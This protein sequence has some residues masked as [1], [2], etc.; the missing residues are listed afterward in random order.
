MTRHPLIPLLLSSLIVLASSTAVS[1]TH[2]VAAPETVT[3]AV[4]VYEW[5]GDPSKPTATR[6]I[7]VSIFIDGHFEDAAVYLSRPVPL[8]LE[9]GNIYSIDE[10]G[11]S[12]GT[13][14]LTS[15]ARLQA[16]GTGA[17]TY[18]ATWLGYGRFVPPSVVKE[19]P[20]R[21]SRNPATIIGSNDDSRPH[22]VNRSPDANPASTGKTDP[23]STKTTTDTADSK[24]TSSTGTDIDRPT[25]RRRTPAEQKADQKAA[26]QS[27]VSGPSTSLNDDPDRPTLHR[28]TAAASTEDKS[29]LMGLPADLHQLT[30]VS[31]PAN[32]PVHPFARPWDDENEHTAI[33]RQLETM[34]HEQLAA[35]EKANP[36]PASAIPVAATT[37][38]PQTGTQTTTTPP[39]STPDAAPPKLE[40]RTTPSATAVTAPTPTPSGPAPS[41][42]A[43]PAT[44]TTA[45]KR[46]AP[47][48]RL[49]PAQRRKAAA[50][51]A[52]A[53]PPP[54]EPLLD[55]QVHEY[56]LSYGGAP[57]FVYTAHTAGEGAARRAI[58]L[59]AQM[60]E[61]DDN[62]L[63]LAL[64]S[65]TDDTHRDRTPEL[66]LVDAVD[67]DASNRASLLFELR[68][69]N[70]RQFALYRVL[71]GR[72]EQLF[73]SG[74]TQ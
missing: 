55:E 2:R 31:D 40:R 3:R 29:R 37:S 24:P 51:A 14:D 70:T 26:S 61:T 25:L 19:T 18:D 42:T 16:N 22:L 43:L 66:R 33:L 35:Y 57:T 73:L 11:V 4:G 45:A 9:Y 21:A 47:A 23:A 48:P 34:A 72:S 38:A 10:A 27:S 54:P 69:Q 13:Y 65:V 17:Y 6:L 30:A 59:V 64:H 68:N 12:H 67:A 41:T 63:L 7:P 56:T 5:T 44:S 49:T 46:T 32:R 53:A 50:A 20:L 8:A 15:A 39:A 52:A 60:D 36:I 71:S 28:N 1:Q 62:K 58:T 74:T